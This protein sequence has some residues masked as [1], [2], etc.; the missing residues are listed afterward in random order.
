LDSQP[1]TRRATEADVP[2]LARMLARAFFDDPVSIWSFKPENLR[3]ALLE[4]FQ[5]TRLRQLLAEDEV[6][7]TPELTSAALW[8]PPK[9]WKTTMRQDAEIMRSAFH[10]RLLA[11]MPLVASGFI[12]MERR[13]PHQPPH[14]YLGMLGTDPSAQGQGLGSAVLGPVLEQCDADGIGAYLE[15]SKERNI[16]FYARHGFRVT[17]ELRMPRGP[18]MWAMWRDARG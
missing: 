8:A 14:W 12:N 1:T 15:S 5:A 3:P 7:T 16:A 11:R 13:H 10:P 4:R 2:A 9:R 6:W 18:K 17:A